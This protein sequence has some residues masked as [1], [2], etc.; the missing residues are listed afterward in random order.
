M[1]NRIRLR[2]FDRFTSA[3]RPKPRRRRHLASLSDYLSSPL[4]TSGT[5]S[6]PEGEGFPPSPMG[7]LGGSFLRW[8][9]LTLRAQVQDLTKAV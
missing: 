4:G 1:S 5:F 2:G 3:W 7:T 9:L 8:L 6:S